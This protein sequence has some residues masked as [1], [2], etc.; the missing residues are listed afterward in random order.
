[1]EIIDSL[2]DHARGFYTGSLGYFAHGGDMEF[3]ILIR[4]LQL[5]EHAQGWDG[6][7][8][9]GAGIVA[10]SNPAREYR[11]T[12]HKAAAWKEILG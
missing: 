10:D 5:H 1:M 2:E 4:S 3:N 12:L 6:Y 9:V 8:H 7:L 11:E